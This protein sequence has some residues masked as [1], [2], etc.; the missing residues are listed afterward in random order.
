MPFTL[1]LIIFKFGLIYES[2]VDGCSTIGKYSKVKTHINVRQEQIKGLLN[3]KLMSNSSTTLQ[4][5]SFAE[6]IEEPNTDLK[7]MQLSKMASKSLSLAYSNHYGTYIENRNETCLNVDC[8][9]NKSSPDIWAREVVSVRMINESVTNNFTR[10][11]GVEK[12]DE[13]AQFIPLQLTP[14]IITVWA[15]ELGFALSEGCNKV[16]CNPLYSFVNPLSLTV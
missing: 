12:T 8:F 9:Y 6:I 16:R 13:V 14:A 4:N 7:T 15:Y 5:S 3:N 2:K 11:W 10:V 1:W